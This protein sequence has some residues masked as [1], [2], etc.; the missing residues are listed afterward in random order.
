MA[1]VGTIS[2][3][4][5]GENSGL[6][7]SITTVATLLVRNVGTIGTPTVTAF[8]RFSANSIVAAEKARAVCFSAIFPRK[9][10]ASTHTA[11]EVWAV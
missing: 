3:R 6:N 5:L 1:K 11:G 8:R 9:T 4:S 7:S 2:G 10:A